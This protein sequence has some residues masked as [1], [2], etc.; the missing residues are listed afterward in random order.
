MPETQ[1]GNYSDGL[2]LGN[3]DSGK[4]WPSWHRVFRIWH[5]SE[6]DAELC[7]NI[8]CIE[9]GAPRASEPLALPSATAMPSTSGTPSA[10]E[11]WLVHNLMHNWA[12]PSMLSSTRSDGLLI[13]AGKLS[14][15][16]RTNSPPSASGTAERLRTTKQSAAENCQV[17]DLIDCRAPLSTDEPP[18]IYGQPRTPRTPRTVI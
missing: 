7:W 16:P 13:T 10:V 5:Y 15:P 11:D 17:H 14:T 1:Q 8:K 4:S 9:P 3:L 12:L 6:S 2:G 18:R